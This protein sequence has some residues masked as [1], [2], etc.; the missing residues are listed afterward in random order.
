MK[1]VS[2]VVNNEPLVADETRHQVL[3]V[4]AEMGYVPHL[5]AQRLASG[6]TRAIALHHPLEDPALISSQVEMDFI[7]GIAMGAAN[8]ESFFS[9]MTSELTQAVVV[10]TRTVSS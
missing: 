7:T 9:L 2:R 4:I 5:Q 6:R 8:Q 10:R 1:T 3:R